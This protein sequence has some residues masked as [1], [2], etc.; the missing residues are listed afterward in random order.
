[1][2]EVVDFENMSTAGLESSPVA[3]GRLP[4]CGKMKRATS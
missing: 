4:A 1:M 3:G 2:P